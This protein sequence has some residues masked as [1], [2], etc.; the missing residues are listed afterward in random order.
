MASNTE[1]AGAAGN[2]NE[3][4]NNDDDVSVMDIIDGLSEEMNKEE[5]KELQDPLIDGFM[6]EN[7]FDKEEV[8]A[9]TELT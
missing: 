1:A 8:K 4:R 2:L 9:E 7:E 3:A 6:N 5:V